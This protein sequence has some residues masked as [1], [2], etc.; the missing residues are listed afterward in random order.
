VNK[1]F[2]GY[3][4]VYSSERQK[5][6][7]KNVRTEKEQKP[8]RKHIDH[9]CYILTHILQKDAFGDLVPPVELTAYMQVEDGEGNGGRKYRGG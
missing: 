4:Y 7:Y 6:I 1:G 2:R 5:K 8:N 9:V 3:A